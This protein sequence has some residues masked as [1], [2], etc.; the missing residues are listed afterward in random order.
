MKNLLFTL[1]LIISLNSYS[2]NMIKVG[3]KSPTIN[4]TDWVLN[5]PTD[6]NLKGKFIVLE[7]WATWCG[8]CIGAV[9]HLN[10]LQEMFKQN[11]LY[12][13]SITDETVEKI[14]RTSKRIPFKSIVVSDQTKATQTAFGDGKEGLVS[15]PMTVLID[16]QDIIRWIGSPEELTADMMNSFLKGQSK[17]ES[18]DVKSIDMPK[19]NTPKVKKIDKKPNNILLVQEPNFLFEVNKLTEKKSVMVIKSDKMMRFTYT[20]LDQILQDFFNLKPYEYTLTDSLKT[21]HYELNFKNMTGKKPDYE[22]LKND[23]FKAMSLKVNE[24][25]KIQ[26]V[27]LVKILDDSKLEKAQNNDY[28]GKSSSG[29]KMIFTGTTISD[30]VNSMSNVIKRSLIIKSDDQTKY[31]F[32]I[33][34]NSLQETIKSMESYGLKVEKVNEKIKVLEITSN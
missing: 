32:I 25:D 18:N 17:T 10:T 9:P 33:A 1:S 24:L 21:Q 4:I 16:N 34:T 3:Q 5:T 27:I 29:D 11:D 23:L 19:I 13:V 6:K 12:F 22:K 2:Q 14:N 7:F 30:M 20:D 28:G 26:E 15:L 31:D 8:P